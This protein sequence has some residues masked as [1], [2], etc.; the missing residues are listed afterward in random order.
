MSIQLYDLATAD[1]K[2]RF[3]PYCWRIKMALAHKGL[4][5]E[6][7]PVHFTE[8]DRL[9]QPNVGTVPVLVDGDTVISDSWTIAGYLDE[10]YPDKPLFA[11][12]ESKATAMLVRFWIER[13]VHPFITRMG[14]VDFM[15]ALHEKDKPYFRES[16]EKRFGMP[17]EQYMN[18]REEA[19]EGFVATLEPL[20]A[21]LAE[22]PYV[23]GSRPA[24]ADYILF[25]ILQWMRC[26]SPFPALKKDDPVF[27]YRERMLDLFD[28]LGRKAAH[29]EQLD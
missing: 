16:R 15:A 22:Q 27:A 5:W 11:C 12:A 3:S 10:R 13:T 1:P 29:R 17:I 9:P 2:L 24:F 7:V 18:N 14:V 4:Q 25:G 21:T 26:G 20:R 6:E 8:K 19:R 23:A 28:G